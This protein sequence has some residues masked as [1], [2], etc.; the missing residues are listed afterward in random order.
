MTVRNFKGFPSLQE[1]ECWGRKVEPEAKLLSLRMYTIL[2]KSVLAYVN[3]LTLECLTFSEFSSCVLNSTD[4]HQ[5]RLR[6]LVSDLK[7]GESRDY[8]CEVSTLKSLEGTKTTLWTISVTRER[9]WSLFA[10]SQVGAYLY[11]LFWERPC[12]RMYL[13]CVW[14]LVNLLD[15]LFNLA[16]PP[17]PSLSLFLCLSVSLCVSVSACLPACLP[18]CL[19]VCL[20]VSLSLSRPQQC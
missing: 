8:G 6:V 2:D 1:V 10:R 19:S 4:T 3:I 11:Q 5:S 14:I 13:G 9:K 16:P 12:V 17:P 7:A 15:L 18:A 20:S